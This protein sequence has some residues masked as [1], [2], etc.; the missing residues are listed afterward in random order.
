M[1]RPIRARIHTDAFRHNLHVARQ[2]AP[3]ARV[4][5]AIKAD[6]YGHGV[7]TAAQALSG[8]DALGVIEPDYAVALREAGENRPILLMEGVF[9]PAELALAAEHRLAI[10]VHEPRQIEWLA[11]AWLPVRLDVWVKMNTG[12]NRLG[13]AP[14]T[15]RQAVARLMQLPQ[16]GSLT[17]MSHFATADEA[18]G[19]AMQ[20]S[21]FLIETE[22]LGLPI[23]LANSAATL[24]HPDT[25]GDWVRPGIMLYGASPCGN[26]SAASFGLQAAMTLESAIIGVQ[27]LESGAAVG[28]GASF[29]AERA[30][31][32]GT[33][34]CG[35]AD[36]YPRVAPTGTPVIVNGHRTRLLGRVSMDML[37]V[38]L[39]GLPDCDV[40]SP[41]ELWGQQ[42]PVDEVAAAA[43]TS[44]YELLSAVTARVPRVVEDV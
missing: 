23:S 31:R 42:L 3:A 40:G 6:G 43:G 14:G 4:M 17:L 18:D 36:G 13:F 21:Q 11:A 33:V 22:G 41:V 5:V 26:R 24:L 34:A 12:M 38:D 1:T 15:L 7:L 37:S 8:A 10:V 2:A 25:H 19:V 20:H 35:Y 32:V 44:G 39:T 28:Y 16:V 30:M 29:V 9:E 27:T